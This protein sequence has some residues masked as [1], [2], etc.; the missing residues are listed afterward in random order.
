MLVSSTWL[1]FLLSAERRLSAV[2]IAIFCSS[3]IVPILQVA[4]RCAQSD[5]RS[6]AFHPTGVSLNYIT[7][8]WLA[9]DSSPKSCLQ[10]SAI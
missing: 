6:A 8:L 7:E 1:M 3:Y 10:V 5:L 4:T 9:C 2:A